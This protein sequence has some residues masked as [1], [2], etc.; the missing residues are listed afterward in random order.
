MLQIASCG[1]VFAFMVLMLANIAVRP[2]CF[3]QSNVCS[4]KTKCSAFARNNAEIGFEADLFH[5]PLSQTEHK[6]VFLCTVI[7][8][9]FVRRL[10][11]CVFC[12]FY[13]NK[14]WVA[15]SIYSVREFTVALCHRN[16]LISIPNM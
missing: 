3:A 15:W 16:W 7:K 1:R 12:A 11:V 8:S 14:H 4:W 9:V 13:N 10:C 5:S 2:V 6:L